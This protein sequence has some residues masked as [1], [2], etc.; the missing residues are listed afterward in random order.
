M[1]TLSA[2][3]QI[4][5]LKLSHTKMVTTAFHL[6]NREA[7]RDLKVYNGNRRL[8]FCP[9][10]ICLWLKLD[11][12]LPF[13]HHLV[14]LHKKL[15]FCVTL[16]R[17]LVG[18]RWGFDTKTLYSWSAQQLSTAPQSGVAVLTH[19]LDSVLND[20]LRIVTKCLRP[21]PTDHFRASSQLSFADQERQ[22]PRITVDL[23][24]L[25][26]SCMLF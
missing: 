17:K 2:H 3:R 7:K 14:A 8:P 18:S 16:L 24:T 12:S 25:I 11:R 4:W 21:T 19:L 10:P 1:S 20:A 13:H 15:F 5:R 6:N 9:T 23:W 26:I 22:S